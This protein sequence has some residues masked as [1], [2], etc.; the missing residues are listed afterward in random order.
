MGLFFK[1]KQVNCVIQFT[2][3]VCYEFIVSLPL[4]YTAGSTQ[5]NNGN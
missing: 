3:F 5:A 1:H 4:L 2:S